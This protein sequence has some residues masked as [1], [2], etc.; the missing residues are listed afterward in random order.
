MSEKKNIEFPFFFVL[1]VGL[2]ILGPCGFSLIAARNLFEAE[3][4]PSG[5]QVEYRARYWLMMIQAKEK[6]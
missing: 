6:H 3:L 1:K 4:V 5:S 2:S